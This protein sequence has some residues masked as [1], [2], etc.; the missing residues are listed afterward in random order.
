MKKF[1]LT[2]SVY[3]LARMES[4]VD[5]CELNFVYSDRIAEFWN[6]FSSIPMILLG[7]FG[8][9][10][11]RRYAST[12]PRFTAAFFFLAVVGIG[13]TTFHATLLWK[14]QLL[15]EIPMLLCN[16]VFIYCLLETRKNRDTHSTKLALILLISTTLLIYL[17]Y[18][19][20][21]YWIF[22]IAYGGGIVYMMYLIYPQFDTISEFSKDLFRKCLVFYFGGF[23]L[24]T[25]ENLFCQ[26]VQPFQF[27]A[28]WHLGAGYG[29]YCW[30]L[31][32]LCS[33][34]DY[35]KRKPLVK[36]AYGIDY[37]TSLN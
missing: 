20:E 15:D 2:N 9:V 25:T 34:L 6:T 31:S 37:I 12:S 17:Y 21:M 1:I 5:W 23:V 36:K 19:W 26:Y 13:S 18:V 3:V 24:W 14:Y 7:I 22:I 30:I 11:T 16:Q 4:T 29:T 27:H 32:L 8:L 35:L 33:R 10:Y 28:W